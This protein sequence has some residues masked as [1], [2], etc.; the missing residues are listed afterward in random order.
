MT[1]RR[2][3]SSSPTTTTGVLLVLAVGLLLPRCRLWNSAEAFSIVGGVTTRRRM[4]VGSGSTTATASTTCH[5]R[6]VAATAT[7]TTTRSTR[8]LFMTSEIRNQ[9]DDEHDESNDND[10]D[11]DDDAV[12]DR[13]RKRPDVESWP[14]RIK[15]ALRTEYERPRPPVR[16]DDFSL[17]LYDVLL[18]LNLTVSISFWV[19]HRMQF[20]YVPDAVSEGCLLSL[21]WLTAG[22]WGGT[23]A[24]LESA[25]DGH[26]GGG[27][28]GGGPVGALQLA[29]QTFVNTINIRLVVAFVVAVS[30]H[31][32]V[33]VDDYYHYHHQHASEALV[34]L[35]LG[36][37]LILM[38]A[39][40]WLHSNYAPR[41]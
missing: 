8:A 23:G 21:C 1:R 25:V 12:D 4:P 32:P 38:P 24:F 19:V 15:K 27:G 31:R 10:D 36:L 14:S 34:P 9:D 29:A 6:F 13:R 16:V 20:Q 17:V 35:E 11:N 40:R 22:L 37:G 30:Q 18:L 2:V 28:G 3:S 7:T 33:L 39:W 5:P 41:L 26:R